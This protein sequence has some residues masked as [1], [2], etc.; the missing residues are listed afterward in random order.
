MD[1]PKRI[2]QHKAQS[3][4]F[5]ILLYKLKDLGIFRGATENDYGIDFEIEFVHNERIIG[6]YLKA[7]VKSAEE[8]FIRQDGIPTVGGIKQATLLYWTELSFRTHVIVFAVDLKTEK[9]YFTDTIFWQATALLDQSDSTKTISFNLPMD[10]AIIKKEA[11]REVTQKLLD[12]F[13]NYAN[14][15]MIKQIGFHSSVADIIYAHK[16]LLRN[17]T[18]IMELYTDLWHYDFHCE[19][20]SLDMFKTILECGKILLRLPENVEGIDKAERTHL[21]NFS[22]WAQKTGWGGDEVTNYIAQT[23]IKVIMPLL[24]DQLE[25]YGKLVLKAK[26]YWKSKNIPYLKMVYETILPDTRTHEAIVRL[27][28]ESFVEKN[29]KDNFY[30]FLCE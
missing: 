22:Y 28:Y 14:T 27:D 23:P 29:K 3:D 11:G 7:Q 12:G 21:F 6:R 18:K 15:I 9:I 10:T 16:N 1:F 8:I 2:Q 19:V 26:Y 4:S 13:E 17:L 30:A 5:A 20:F 24:L 25:E